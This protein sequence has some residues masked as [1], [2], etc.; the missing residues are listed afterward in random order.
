MK[1]VQMILLAGILIVALAVGA[2]AEPVK[3]GITKFL[4]HRA[5]DAVERAVIEALAQAGYVE[6]T[7]V[8]Y[9]RTSAQL[10]FSIAQAI[11]QNYQAQ[12]VDIVVAIAT[13]SALAAAEVF[14]GSETPV[15]FAAITAPEEYG[16]DGFDNVTGVSDLID[17]KLDLELLLRID[18]GIETVGMV[19]NPGEANS[20]YLT[21]LT[22]DIAETLDLEIVTAAAENSSSVQ[23]AAQSLIGRVDAI[24]ATTDNT[25]A[26]ALE[27]VS[28]AAVEAGIP[29]L[30]ADPT[31]IQNG[32]TVCAGWDYYSH[33]L[34]VAGFLIDLLEGTPMS[35]LPITYQKDTEHNERE[36]IL[37][38][39]AS[40]LAG[41]VFSQAVI[42]EATSLYAAG[43]L[44]IAELSDTSTQEDTI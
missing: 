1:S 17:P 5:L 23:L 35:E 2:S 11:A 40:E 33:G 7:D 28:D 38:L 4:D 6:G 41:V 14:G 34:I 20:A 15:I 43:I 10:D 29:F 42:A 26:G 22:K 13:P 18:P 31:S 25:V 21:D 9:L 37:S 32:P 19:Y 44:W 12:A 27:A 36:V 39:D 16:L 24:Y 30:M 8:E 3:I